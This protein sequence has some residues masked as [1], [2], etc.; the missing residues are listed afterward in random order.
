MAC[1]Q[2]PE[3]RQPSQLL[4]ELGVARTAGLY[5][6]LEEFGSGGN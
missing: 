1:I 2:N 3:F 6:E 5:D 4:A